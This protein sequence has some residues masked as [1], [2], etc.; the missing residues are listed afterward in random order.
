MGERDAIPELRGRA[1]IV[2][3]SLV[4]VALVGGNRSLEGGLLAEIGKARAQA[5][6]GDLAGALAQLQELA[7]R[8]P[9]SPAIPVEQARLAD[10]PARKDEHTSKALVLAIRGGGA[11][12]AVD[13]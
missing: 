7:R 6:A 8:H 3:I 2:A 9:H 4:V 11:R 10:D 1:A 12:L 13:I 5:D